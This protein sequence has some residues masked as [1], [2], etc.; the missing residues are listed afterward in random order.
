MYSI[1]LLLVALTTTILFLVRDH[2]DTLNVALLYLT[3]VTLLSIWVDTRS[4][5]VASVAAFLGFNFFFIEPYYTF[6]VARLDHI[7]VLFVFLGSAILITNLVVRVRARTAEALQRARQTT[8]LYHLSTVLIG[9]VGLDEMLAALVDRVCDVFALDACIILLDVHGEL[10]PRA[11][12]GEKIDLADP[13][14]LGIARGMMEQCPAV[15]TGNAPVASPG[16][17]NEWELV[18]AEFGHELLFIPITSM[19]R[20]LG[21]LIV[22]TG[23][24]RARFD[25]D[26]AQLLATFANQAAIAIERSLLIEERTRAEIL[27]RSD[28]LKSALLSAVSHDLR[29]PLA[30]IKASATSLLQAGVTWTDTER[31]ELLE[32]INEEAD[33]LNQLVANLLDLS[34]IESGALRPELAWYDLSEVLHD[35]VDRTE[36]QLRAY[37]L[38][39]D[40]PA[41]L[42]LLRI[43]FVQIGQVF[44]NLLENAAKYAKPGT[45]IILTARQADHAVEIVV[46]DEGVGI[47][48]GEEERIFDKFYRVDAPR[49]PL[50][51]GVGLAICRGIV[52]AHGGRIWAE[53][54]PDRGL[55]IRF[56]LPLPA[57]NEA[58]V[59]RPEEVRI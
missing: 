3:V 28:A 18:Q 58:D 49:R 30:S 42:P 44:V 57:P 10:T 6:D 34:R 27:A 9:E 33:R 14:L 20:S 56:T 23:R 24:S 16:C 59:I 51:S 29:T 5:I 7:L 2:L 47:P 38:L 32:A 45:R 1:A 4:G 50:G 46:R 15:D 40:V 41:D 19:R 26:D 39:V 36:P 25:A 21:V 37:Q 31:R 13:R 11:A 22:V 48:A 12:T 43:D 53:R 52:E 55:T 54:N 35:A 8:T 17:S